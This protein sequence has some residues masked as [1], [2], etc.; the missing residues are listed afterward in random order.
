MRR[1]EQ[2]Q[3]LGPRYLVRWQGEAVAE[4]LEVA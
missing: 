4:P 3:G 2:L 1:T